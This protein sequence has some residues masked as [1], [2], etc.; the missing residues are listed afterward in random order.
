MNRQKYIIGID[1]GTQSTKL[2]IYDLDGQAVCKTAVKLKPMARPRAGIAEHPGDDL[3][4][5]LKAAGRQ[6]MELFPHPREEIL[7]IGLCSIRCCRALLGED[8][9]L[10]TPVQSWMDIRT[11]SAYINDDPGVRWVTTATGYLTHRLTG[12]FKDTAANHKGSWPINYSRSQWLPDGPDFDRFNI[13]REQLFEL[14]RPGDVLGHVT[15]E[16]ARET[17]LPEGL[18]V[19]ATANDKAVEALGAGLAREDTG[20]ISLGTF[21][22]SMVVG[23]RYDPTPTEYWTN[24]ACMPNAFLNESFGVANGMSTVSW[25]RDLLG[26]EVALKAQAE[27]LTPEQFL[28]REAAGVEPGC[29]GLMTVPNWLTFSVPPFERGIMVGFEGRHKREHMYRSI[30]EGLAFSIT[31]KLQDMLNA[32][33]RRLER[34]IVTGGGA[35]S[36]LVMQIFADVLGLP[37]Q[38]NTVTDAAGLGAAISAAVGLGAFASYEEAIGRMVSPEAGFAP[39]MQTHALYRRVI[40]E[41]YSGLVPALLELQRKSYSIFVEGSRGGVA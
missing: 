20:L 14:V 23:D 18:P 16:A 11:R 22:T 34:V 24:L 8:A 9:R 26:D 21:V 3:W 19:V 29:F 15:A 30:L 32:L 37:T 7:G 31:G 6:I 17:G 1:G 13:R 2:V 35:K 41:V 33:P 10:V 36:D 4:D 40:D 25:F 38:R 39:D 5:S 12:A 27:G 28:D